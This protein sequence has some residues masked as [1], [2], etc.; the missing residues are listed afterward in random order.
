MRFAVISLCLGAALWGQSKPDQILIFTNVNVIDVRDGEIYRNMT[1]VI[2]EGRVASVAHIGLIGTGR[3]LQVVNAGGRYLI[4]GLWDMHAHT[5]G[6]SAPWDERVLYPQYIANGVTGLREVGGDPE[7]LAQ[8]A[9]DIDSGRL[10]GPHLVSY[11]VASNTQP[12]QPEG[13]GTVDA[14]KKRGRDF[15]RALSSLSRDALL[16]TTS[17]QSPKLTYAGD[18]PDSISVME[19]PMVGEKSIE[20]LAGVQLACSSKEPELRKQRLEALADHDLAA[21]SAA[22]MQMMNT[23]DPQKAQKLYLE[24]AAH[25]TW[26]VPALVWTQ[27]LATID[28]PQIASDPRL[29]YVPA[30][31]RGDWDPKNLLEGTAPAQLTPAKRQ[32][33]EQL[34]V[35]GAMHRTGV[36]FLAGTDG[37]DP[38]VFPGSSLHEEL[39]LLVKSGFSPLEALQTA[40]FN[41]GLFMAKLDK[42]GVI[43][44]GHMADLVLLEDNPLMNIRNTRR[45]FAV[46]VNGRYYSR[47]DLDHM[48]VQVQELAAKE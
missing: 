20:H 13:R 28:S 48:L 36:Q 23:Y 9:H 11:D 6:R 12:H 26:Q 38:F 22:T 3:N 35:V 7:L 31:I 24:L 18:Y 33:Y 42:Y 34:Q 29:L 41:P 43:E 37:P 4:P 25:A 2:Q 27:A 15:V 10:L 30:S 40:T 17:A 45:I 39:E 5:V 1:V 44:K 19:A 8:R 14:V 46:V 16:A 32:A 47:R 21:Y